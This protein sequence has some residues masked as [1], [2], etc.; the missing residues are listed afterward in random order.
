MIELLKNLVAIKSDTEEGANEALQYCSTWLSKHNIDHKVIENQGRLMIHAEVGQGPTTIVWNGHVDV[1]P[2]KPEQF[3]PLIEG[4]RLY[5]RGSADMKAGVAAMMEAFK[6]ISLTPEALSNRIV[7]HI[8][9]D[10]EVGGRKTSGHLVEQGFTGDFVICGEPTQLKLSVQSKGLL[11][12]NVT[13]LGKAAHGSRPWEGKNAIELSYEFHKQIQNLPF[14]KVNNTYYEHPSINL[15]RIHAGDRYNMVPDTCEMG[16]D[17][18]YV[19][20]QT[21]EDILEEITDLALSINKE[22]TVKIRAKTAPI[23]TPE[24][25]H[26][27]KTLS[28]LTEE[29]TQKE[30]ILFGQH[31][32]ADTRY[33]AK[34][35][36][37]AI[38][39]G[40][41]GDDWHGPNEYVV[42]SSVE[43]Y[44]DILTKHALK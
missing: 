2:A 32:T 18:R 44:A 9:T 5:G 26:Y 27:V 21:W 7:L 13:F 1:V 3:I 8:V 38:E 4:D 29:I 14:T 12:L 39:F 19:P 40:P 43:D 41:A 34:T 15:A 33:Y 30:T 6:R 37:C 42:L 20:G 10:E 25:E 28:V 24:D 16:Y 22:S 11:Q 35:G 36:A 17:I 31:G 23:V